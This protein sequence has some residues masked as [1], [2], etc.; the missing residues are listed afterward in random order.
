MFAPTRVARGDL[1]WNVRSSLFRFVFGI[2]A[3]SV[4]LYP[5]LAR[6]CCPESAAPG[7][8]RRRALRDGFGFP[9]T[10]LIDTRPVPARDRVEFWA[11][12]SGELYHPLHI[13]RDED[14][15]GEFEA[16]MWADRLTSIGLFRVAASANTMTRT[17]QDIATGD[18]ERLHVSIL[19]RGRLHGEQDSRSSTLGPGDITIY[20]TSAPA[21]FHAPDQFDLL[22]LSLPK[23]AL[24]RDAERLS[25]LTAL[26]IPGHRGLPRLAAQFFRGVGSGVADGSIGAEDGDVAEEVMHLVIRLYAELDD[27]SPSREWLDVDPL[28]RPR[29]FIDQ[30]LSDP[31]LDPTHVARAC[32]IS[33]RY[34]HRLFA[35]A[36]ASVSSYIRSE[37]LARCRQDLL[38]PSL[39]D[40]P[41]SAIGARWGLQNASHFSR[42]FRAAYGSSPRD[43]RRSA[44]ADPHQHL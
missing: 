4:R 35:E 33:T 30:S 39:A 23:A 17:R 14:S 25:R 16:L 31:S 2:W 37:R 42:V 3:A 10:L 5:W 9:L 22:V 19:L 6:R 28:A 34:L 21:V 43:F 11:H 27:S 44:Q 15:P 41:V 32:F 1:A 7:R 36:G 26:R 18:P 13:R 24:G 38:D 29:A 12:S 8:R 20:D 40:E